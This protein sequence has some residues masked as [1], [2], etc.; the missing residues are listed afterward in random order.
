MTDFPSPEGTGPLSVIIPCYNH[1]P[2]LAERLASIQAQTV[3][4]LSVLF[5][6]D[7]SRDDSFDEARRLAG[8]DPRFVFQRTTA[9]TGNPFAVWRLGL[10][11][12]ASR[13]VWIAESDDACTPDF[14][15]TLLPA[16]E[17]DP[18]VGLA[19]CQSVEIDAA[20]RETGTLQRHTDDI[21]FFRWRSDYVAEGTDECRR[22]L[23]FRNTIPN[24]SACVFRTEALR[25][26]LEAADGFQLCGDWAIYVRLF[27]SGWRVAYKTRP[28]NRYRRHDSTRRQALA[29]EVEL[30]E[31]AR[32]RLALRERVPL[33]VEVV[34]MASDMTRRRLNELARTCGP[35]EAGVWF[36]NGELLRLLIAFDPLFCDMLAGS[37]PNRIFWCDIYAAADG[38][39]HEGNKATLAYAANR[40]T[41]LRVVVPAG[42][43]RIDPGREA[44]LYRLHEVTIRDPATGHVVARFEGTALDGL[45]AA[46]TCLI[47]DRHPGLLVYAYGD[48]PILV[49]PEFVAPR[50]SVLL[51][52][53]LTGHGLIG[54]NPSAT[55]SC[56]PV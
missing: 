27:T 50:P 44:G 6:D 16:L 48:D 51:E 23:V 9:P 41:V 53:D 4:D 32:I 26:A 52:I 21:D 11:R 31:T 55:G 30:L 37:A 18:S 25:Q 49:L 33:G 10:E 15:E 29:G 35:T 2:Y 47:L 28:C 22:G 38:T 13:F 5:L 36:A 8:Q 1:A 14:L 17:S 54:Q 42:R 39:F 12:T 45:A 46:G 43:L 56:S 34:A 19:Y 24:A 3:S 20:G 40:R 7:G